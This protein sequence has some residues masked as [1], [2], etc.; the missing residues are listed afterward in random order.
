MTKHQHRFERHLKN[1]HEQSTLKAEHIHNHNRKLECY[2]KTKFIDT[3]LSV[4]MAPKFQKRECSTL[5]CQFCGIT[6]IDHSNLRT[7]YYAVHNHCLECQITLESRTATLNHVKTVK[8]EDKAKNLT[9]EFDCKI[10]GCV[11][12]NQADL[13]KH[14]YAM[15]NHCFEC[16]LSFNS[17]S[18]ALNHMKT[19]HEAK[20]STKTSISEEVTSRVKYFTPVTKPTETSNLPKKIVPNGTKTGI[21]EPSDLKK[22]TLVFTLH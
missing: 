10:C 11:K 8:H 20:K 13:E 21:E 3:N 1:K 12:S 5:Q 17:K 22:G 6:K 14:C 2:D 18:A 16:Q 9:T 15:H 4:D 19:V 7:H